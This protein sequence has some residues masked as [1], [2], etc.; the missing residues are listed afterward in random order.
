MHP[1]CDRLRS[2]DPAEDAAFSAQNNW[3]ICACTLVSGPVGASHQP[4]ELLIG[5]WVLC[6]EPYRYAVRSHSPEM[7]RDELQSEGDQPLGP[8]AVCGVAPQIT[9]EQ[10]LFGGDPSVVR[11]AEQGRDEHNGR[12]AAGGERGPSPGHQ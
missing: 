4:M 3:D 9:A 2:L 11:D 8:L 6:N 1:C 10:L 5:S 7:A 12:Q